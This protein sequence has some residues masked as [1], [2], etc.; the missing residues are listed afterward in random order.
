MLATA[1][2]S[3]APYF[4]GVDF[5]EDDVL[6]L[7]QIG[8]IGQVEFP[9]PWWVY[10]FFHGDQHFVPLTRLFFYGLWLAFGV[11]S[12]KWQIAVT[13]VHALSA[14]LFYAVLRRYLQSWWPC[15]VAAVV[16]AGVAIDSFDSPLAWIA[17]CEAYGFAVSGFLVAMLGVS[18][19]STRPA[20][21]MLVVFAGSFASM[22]AWNFFIVMLPFLAV[23]YALLERQ[24]GRR[25]QDY[26]FGGWLAL[27]GVMFVLH[28]L[29]QTQLA[30]G[31]Q[32][33]LESV[34]NTAFLAAW[35]ARV[36]FPAT[37]R[38]WDAN[39]AVI[40]HELPSSAIAQLAVLG[41]LAAGTAAL[42]TRHRAAAATR[43]ILVFLPVMIVPLA[44]TGAIRHEL[45][46]RYVYVPVFGMLGVGA[47]AL[48][49]ALQSGPR[50]RGVALALSMLYL[51]VVKVHHQ[52]M[53]NLTVTLHKD[54]HGP[55]SAELAGTRDSLRRLAEF[56]RTQHRQVRIIDSPLDLHYIDAVFYTP[57]RCYAAVATPEVLTDVAIIPPD[58]ATVDDFRETTTV[59]KA[60]GDKRARLWL[61]RVRVLREDLAA[62]LWLDRWAGE[63]NQIVVLPPIQFSYEYL[64]MVIHVP[65]MFVAFSHPLQN[66]SFRLARQI[67]PAQLKALRDELLATGTPEARRMLFHIDRA[68]LGAHR[69]G[70]A[71]A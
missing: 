45:F 9:L 55:I 8:S 36:L 40:L 3:H 63:H 7:I 68:M 12:L 59:L 27:I 69:Q 60:V 10:L 38:L 41:G 65:G 66:V 26:L 58:L 31:P 54:M 34:R 47:A 57:L 42:M 14:L 61:E 53:A 5:Q 29:I 2:L 25:K 1:F 70:H 62:L 18:V 32:L 16:W 15:F 52:S 11:D 56:A 48:D 46:G 20:L 24:P 67:T 64:H 37:P 39:D 21:G 13:L 71:G 17:A 49:L 19:I 50:V 30:A 43:L 4:Q 44:L 33:S 51:V 22:A 6:W 23:Q 28:S 35:T